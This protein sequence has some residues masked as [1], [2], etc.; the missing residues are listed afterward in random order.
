[1]RTLRVAWQAV[2]SDPLRSL[3][4]AIAL[5]LGMLGLLSVAAAHTVLSDA[6]SARALMAGG[7]AATFRVELHPGLSE[8]EHA[9]YAQQLSDRA[10]AAQH[11]RELWVPEVPVRVDGAELHLVDLVLTEPHSTELFPVALTSGRWPHGLAAL[12]PRAVLNA[13]ALELIQSTRLTAEFEA[14]RTRIVPAGRAVDGSTVP[15]LYLALSDRAHVPSAAARTFVLL[16]GPHLTREDVVRAAHELDTFD[17]AGDVV[18]V[19]RIDTITELEAELNATSRALATLGLLSMAATLIG[20]LNLGLAASSARAREFE[21]R[22]VFGA[23]RRQI[24]MVTLLESQMISVFAGLIAIVGSWLVF[25]GVVSSFGLPEGGEAPAFPIHIGVLSL[26]L[27]AGA[28]LLASLVPAL[29]SFRRD[30]SRVMRY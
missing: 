15:T 20:A 9:T 4:S 13:A 10:G 29:I 16:T 23:S 3:L 6:I 21:L 28:G 18:E 30:I 7:P 17:V 1:M 12:A 22:R 26:G 2:R 24:G 5:M 27:S 25:P 8:A 19:E 14:W 11:T